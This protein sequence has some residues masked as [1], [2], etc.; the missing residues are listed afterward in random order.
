QALK[1][2]QKATQ[3]IDVNNELVTTKSELS[4]QTLQNNMTQAATKLNQTA[5]QLVIASKGSSEQLAAT[6]TEISQRFDE[7]LLAGLKLAS[8]SS[9]AEHQHEL[10]E[11]LRTISVSSTKLLLAAKALAADP[12]APNIKNQ[13]AAAARLV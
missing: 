2:I 8:C 11:Y 3:Q 4:Y 7:L 13:L 9:D 6:A 12:N 5:S 10:L 1:S